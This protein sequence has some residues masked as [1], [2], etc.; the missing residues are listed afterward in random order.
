MTAE[1]KLA[2]DKPVLS[3][4]EEILE[5]VR[6]GKPV[7]IVDDEDRE[8]EGDLI[9]AAAKATPENINFMAREGRGLICL[10][11]EEAIVDRLG[12]QLMGRGNNSRHRTAFTV[13]IE[14]REGVTTG[15]SA[16]DR[17]KTI[18]TAID[19]KSGPNDIATPGH[20][21]PLL[22]REGGVL[23]RAG[24]TEAAVDL[25]RLAGLTAAGVICEIM[26][27]DGTM[28]RLDD[29]G[30]FSRK[31]NL[32]IGT[33]ADLIAHRR[34]KECLVKRIHEGT[35]DSRFGGNFKMIVYA[36]TL[37]Y[38]EHIVLVKGDIASTKSPVLVRMHAVD[39]LGDILGKGSESILHK[40]MEHIAQEGRG[41]IVI[42]REPNPRNLTE[43]LAQ[44]DRVQNQSPSAAN[45][46]DYGI[47]AQILLDL[48]IRDMI[49]LSNSPKNVIGLEGYDLHIHGQRTLT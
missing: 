43:R 11:M 20:I 37:E 1:L 6:S 35:L 29:L 17:A 41:V 5:D 15:I 22:A 12:L 30:A 34:R 40:A 10:P 48:G 23:V 32:R 13:S 49:L 16:A 18:E 9:I 31:H 39:I 25:A 7:I 8:N 33:I 4:I 2:G 3:S 24:H 14:A 47:G 38:A 21:F 28:A 46:R 19:P 26:N 36:N 27:D 44:R 42:L 45:L